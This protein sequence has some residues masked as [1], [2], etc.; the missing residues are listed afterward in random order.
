MVLKLEI[1]K[2]SLKDIFHAVFPVVFLFF[3]PHS[4]LLVALNILSIG[5][6]TYVYTYLRNEEPSRVA[7]IGMLFQAIITTGYIEALWDKKGEKQWLKLIGITKI[8][9]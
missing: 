7:I 1:T 5:L 6:K 4:W 8:V 2:Q 3:I 9:Y